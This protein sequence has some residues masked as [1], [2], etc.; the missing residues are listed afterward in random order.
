[1]CAAVYAVITLASSVTQGLIAAKSRI[2]KKSLTIPRLEL[3]SGHMTVN[4]LTNVRAALE[5]FH[6][7]EDIQC[8][9]DSTVALHLLNDDGEYRQFVANRV[10]KIQSHP[11]TQGRHVPTSEN[12]ADLGSRGG[13]VNET[14][15][16]WNG[17]SWLFDPSQWPAVTEA[18]DDSNA[19]KKVQR[20]LFALGV[21]ANDDFDTVLGKFGLRKAMRICAWISRFNHNSRHPSENIIGLLRPKKFSNKKCP[22]LS[23]RRAKGQRQSSLPVIRNN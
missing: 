2:A 7:M 12:P 10:K 21:E 14:E 16:W 1:M 15:L 9:L 5:G 11:N 17:P 22:G 3:M 4:L 18:V 23:E 6:M 20:E 8:W 13:S 19:E